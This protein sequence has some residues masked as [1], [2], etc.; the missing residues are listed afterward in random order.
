M[1]AK[2]YKNKIRQVNAQLTS[3]TKHLHARHTVHE[4][5]K[6]RPTQT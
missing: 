4:G 6:H 1:L 5:R 3:S 2:V